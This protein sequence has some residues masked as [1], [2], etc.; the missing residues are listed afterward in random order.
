[1]GTLKKKLKKALYAIPR[2]FFCKQYFQ[3]HQGVGKKRGDPWVVK[4]Q[5]RKGPFLLCKT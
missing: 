1:M 3:A 5:I 4:N 2:I